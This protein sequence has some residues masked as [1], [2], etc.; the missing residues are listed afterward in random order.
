MQESGFERWDVFMKSEGDMEAMD[1]ACL[2]LDG[3][4]R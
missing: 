4:D 3:R 1:D 2:E